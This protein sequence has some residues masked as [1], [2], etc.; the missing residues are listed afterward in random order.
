MARPQRSWNVADGRRA[1]VVP[2]TALET[3]LGARHAAPSAATWGSSLT[4]HLRLPEEIR[5]H[6]ATQAPHE[7]S[8]RERLVFAWGRDPELLVA[9]MLA[10]GLHR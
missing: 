5:R 2:E 6:R 4:S 8:E 1:A 9:F 7:G 10:G 3:Q